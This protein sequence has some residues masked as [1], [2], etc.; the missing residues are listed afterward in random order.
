MPSLPSRYPALLALAED[1]RLDPPPL[2]AAE[3][4]DAAHCWLVAQNFGRRDITTAAVV[5]EDA[6]VVA[7]IE[8]RADGI[9]SGLEAAADVFRILDPGAS[10]VLEL[11]DGA[12]VTGGELILRVEGAAAA[13]LIAERTALNLLQHLSGVATVTRSIV[14]AVADASVSVLDTRKTTPGLRQLERAAVRA[15]G[16]TSHRNGLSDQVLLKENH[17]ALS[18]LSYRETVA[19]AVAARSARTDSAPGEEP[20]VIA[21]ARDEVEAKAAVEGG[22]GVILLD[23]FEPGDRLRALLDQLRALARDAGREVL[24]EVS[25]GIRPDTAGAYAAC[26]IDRLSVGMVTHSAPALDMSLLMDPAVEV[27]GG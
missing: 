11:Q 5:P 25:G 4:L 24:F 12:R 23:N 22:A 3:D 26:G 8:A 1:L 16:G 6:W 19:K 15:G 9:L 27:T 17:F 2:A 21:E 10:V 13:V 14:A 20:A 7:R 18:G